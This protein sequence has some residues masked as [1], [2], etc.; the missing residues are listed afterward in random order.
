METIPYVELL[1]GGNEIKGDF[2]IR[3]ISGSLQGAVDGDRTRFSFEAMDEMDPV[4][5]TGTITGE[6]ERM[7]V[8]LESYDG[9]TFAFGRARQ[10]EQG[11]DRWL[12]TAAGTSST[13]TTYT[14]KSKHLAHAHRSR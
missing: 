9:D 2:Q 3:L 12:P 4:N 8:V 13:G 7:T 10:H 5:G 1:Q 6:D 14:A 11:V